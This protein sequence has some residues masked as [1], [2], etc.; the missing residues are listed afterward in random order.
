MKQYPV[1][2]RGIQNLREE[3]FAP[4]CA[5]GKTIKIPCFGT[6]ENTYEVFNRLMQDNVVVAGF[7]PGEATQDRVDEVVFIARFNGIYVQT[8]HGA[9]QTEIGKKGGDLLLVLM[10]EVEH[11][12]PETCAPLEPEVV[13]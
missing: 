11:V 7:N 1:L 2:P 6:D 13:G 8:L 5:W 3:D 12:V 9:I 4:Y 10:D